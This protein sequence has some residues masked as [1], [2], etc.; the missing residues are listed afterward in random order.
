MFELIEFK[1]W[2]NVFWIGLFTLNAYGDWF[3]KTQR[4]KCEINRL[5]DSTRAVKMGRAIGP[6]DVKM[7]RAIGPAH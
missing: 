1:L 3:G 6:R 2:N 5:A 4:H 7:R